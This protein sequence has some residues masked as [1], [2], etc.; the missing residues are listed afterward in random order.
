MGG[1]LLQ[2][3]QSLLRA[4]GGGCTKAHESGGADDVMDIT[5]AMQPSLLFF[6]SWE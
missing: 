2:G 1:T 5:A 4:Q 3:G 6:R